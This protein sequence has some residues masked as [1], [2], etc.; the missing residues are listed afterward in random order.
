MLFKE[1]VAFLERLEKTDSRLEM[2]EIVKELFLSSSD[3]L[4]RT[5]LYVQG[6]LFP[7]W[8]P[9]ELG[10]ASRMMIKCISMSTGFSEDVI[11]EIIAK[12]G[13]TGLACEELFKRKIQTTL[14]QEDLSLKTIEEL[15]RKISKLEGPGSQE[16]KSKY[17]VELL[18]SCSA[19]EVKY[20][21][22]LLLGEMRVGVGEGIVRDAVAKAWNIDAAIVEG[23][24]SLINDYGE[25]AELAREKGVEGLKKID[26]RLG[27]P[28]RP[29]LAQ[30]VHS[31]EEAFKSFKPGIF[32]Y[33]YDG[34]RTQVHI[35]DGKI[36][37]F[38]RRL[39]DV[40]KQFPDV[41]EAIREGITAKNAIIEGETVAVEPDEHPRPFQVLSRR[42]KRKHGIDQMAEE[43]PII[44]YLF[45]CMYLNN[46]NYVK[47]RFKERRKTLESI[48]T[49][50]KRLRLSKMLLTDKTKPANEFYKEAL[51]KGHE[52]VMIKNPEANY[53]PGSRVGY[54][55]KL[56][57]IAETIDLVIVGAEW[58]EGRRANWLGS[59]LLACRDPDTGEFLEIGKMA[60]GLSD[61]QLEMLTEE[62]KPDIVEQKNKLVK[63]RPR[64][65]VEVG[66]QEIQ[67]SPTY[68]SGYALRFPRLIRI[69]ED[70]S[71]E[72]AETLGRIESLI[73]S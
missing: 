73:K 19:G 5:V 47:V 69:R 15:T 70:R 49:E 62:L 38:T 21:V 55:Y 20:M 58:G 28:L 6:L 7:P 65:V 64:V 66:Y 36:K 3:D 1:F 45:D 33:K 48:V 50:G 56:K 59:Y 18:N 17:I 16:K 32:E 31:V 68:A 35:F 2:T 43:I 71:P 23:A 10:I 4:H 13:D 12:T 25:L 42:I 54:M 8:D 9:S 30:S 14:F 72:E 41:V 27:R 61:E 57:P 29:M 26:L 52:G 22:R 44:L 46:K 51:D 40:T 53:K 67:K 34:M 39:E 37:I 24:F 11:Q 60:T 63:L